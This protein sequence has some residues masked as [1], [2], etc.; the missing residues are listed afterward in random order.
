[1]E[2]W[3]IEP[4]KYLFIKVC[5]LQI[6]SI[7]NCY[8]HDATYSFANCLAIGMN[9]EMFIEVSE[10]CCGLVTLHSFTSTKVTIVY[11]NFPQVLIIVFGI[12][13]V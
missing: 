10:D 6:S 13:I 7:S 12:H 9:V 8:S 4:N 1:M 2:W 11:L 3:R 5:W